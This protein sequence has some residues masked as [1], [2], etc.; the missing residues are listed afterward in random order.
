ML[1]PMARQ[2]NL[3]ELERQFKEIQDILYKQKRI[4][5]KLILEVADREREIL[6]LRKALGLCL[7][8]VH[9]KRPEEACRAII[10]LVREAL[11]SVEQR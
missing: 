6:R 3:V 11:V 10:I 5:A 9:S 7:A 2:K 4:T 1:E 8:S